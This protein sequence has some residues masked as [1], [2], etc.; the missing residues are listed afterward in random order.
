MLSVCLYTGP[1]SVTNL[2]TYEV[3]NK[4]LQQTHLR[5]YLLGTLYLLSLLF[6][7]VIIIFYFSTPDRVD[8][9]NF[10]NPKFCGFDI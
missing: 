6:I 8:E 5:F 2:S 10:W 3:E 9:M 7:T 1:A 4:Y